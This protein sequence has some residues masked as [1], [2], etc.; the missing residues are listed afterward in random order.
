[1]TVEL[2]PHPGFGLRRHRVA[3]GAAKK[4]SRAASHAKKKAKGTGS[5][6]GPADDG[7]G[8]GCGPGAEEAVPDPWA[9]ALARVRGHLERARRYRA[10]LD[11]GAGRTLTELGE[12][13][14]ITKA[15]VSQLVSLLDLVA[16]I[17]EDI[18]RPDRTGPVPSEL[19]LRHIAALP[20]AERQVARYR[21]VCTPAAPV[22]GGVYR[23]EEGG[24]V[25]APRG[26][27]FQHL[28]ARARR[29]QAL[30]D[31]GEMESLVEIGRAEGVSGARV[32]QVLLFLHLA[33]E[34]SAVLD[35]PAG[36]VPAGVGVKAMREIARLRS[37]EAQRRE[38]EARWPGVLS[39]AVAAK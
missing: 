6:C 34:I 26:E 9:G 16:E 37:Q 10:W 18:E 29:Y 19:V 3:E 13:E 20:D 11:G 30:L 23:R 17:V 33:P 35:V 36:E 12:L 39:G 28:F 22:S 5:D 8:Q 25:P 27:G 21:A 1:M 2:P 31:S 32:S 7:A 14:G 15:R 4:R 24:P 38:F